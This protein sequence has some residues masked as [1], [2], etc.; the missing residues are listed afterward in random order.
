[1]TRSGLASSNMILHGVRDVSVIRAKT[2]CSPSR[3]EEN[4]FYKTGMDGHPE[5]WP[6]PTSY[7]PETDLLRAREKNR[8]RTSKPL[9]GQSERFRTPCGSTECNYRVGPGT[10]EGDLLEERPSTSSDFGAKTTFTRERRRHPVEMDLRRHFPG[11]GAYQSRRNVNERLDVR[12]YARRLETKRR[13]NDRTT[14]STT[15][16]RRDSFWLTIQNSKYGQTRGVFEPGPAS[17]DDKRRMGARTRSKRGVGTFGTFKRLTLLQNLKMDGRFAESPGPSTG[18][19][20]GMLNMSL[21]D[22]IREESVRMGRRSRMRTK[23]PSSI[24]ANHV[25]VRSPTRRSRNGGPPSLSDIPSWT[26]AN[27]EAL[28]DDKIAR[29]RGW[30]RL[31]TRRENARLRKETGHAKS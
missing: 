5:K 13:A 6:A 31:K 9:F 21:T 11:P 28:R 18:V 17:Y 29:R 25:P 27:S 19:H 8:P 12:Q 30:T 24:A 10:Y 20:P 3:R 26:I 16:R 1:M 2:A 4:F 22:R 14:R 7:D 15:S 23:R